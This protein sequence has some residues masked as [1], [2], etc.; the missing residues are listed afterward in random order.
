LTA[1]SL[2]LAAMWGTDAVM[3]RR[4]AQWAAAPARSISSRFLAS[5]AGP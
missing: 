3:A 5:Q 2:L 4:L 1:L